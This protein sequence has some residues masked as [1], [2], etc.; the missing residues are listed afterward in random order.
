MEAS[1]EAFQ[2]LVEFN[3]VTF[4]SNETVNR[5]VRILVFNYL[6]EQEDGFFYPS[7]TDDTG[8]LRE[9]DIQRDNRSGIVQSVMYAL[10]IIAR[11][12][13][14]KVLG[15][16]WINTSDQLLLREA[17]E[18]MSRPED[19]VDIGAFKLY[20]EQEWCLA[21]TS[22]IEHCGQSGVSQEG[23]DIEGDKKE[24]RNWGKQFLGELYPLKLTHL[25][26]VSKG[27]FP[28]DSENV[29]GAQYQHA[30]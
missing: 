2:E 23:G 22:K 29:W 7:L 16:G 25:Q 19:L 9:S 4:T 8:G 11:V 10:G 15:I 26:N 14:P 17:L 21:I 6:V 1:E 27:F 5:I 12:S 28:A 18:A 3:E 24:K 13:D 30:L 20:L